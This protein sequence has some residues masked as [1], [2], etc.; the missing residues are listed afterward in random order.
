MTAIASHSGSSAS[1][2]GAFSDMDIESSSG[3]QTAFEPPT[4]AHKMIGTLNLVFAG[5]LLMCGACTGISF[6]LQVAM[7]PMTEG[8]QNA[9]QEAMSAQAEQ[10]REQK[11]DSLKEQVEAATSDDD[12]ARIEAEIDE[13]QQQEPVEIPKFDMMAA[14]RDPQIIGFMWTDLITALVLNILLFVSGL[15]LLAAKAWARKLAIW[16]AALKIVRLVTLYGYSIAVVVPIYAQ[17]MSQMMEQM[18]ASM[19][20]RPGAPAMPPMG[21]TLGTF[22]GVAMSAGAVLMILVGVIYPIVVLWVL[23]RPKVKAACGETSALR[24]AESP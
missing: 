5:L 23:T 8:Y 11:I 20:K 10:E 13:L 9:M 21:Q 17:K 22:Y 15:G 1:T 4:S 3:G 18:T 12:R 24:P 7:A 16:T 6:L 2:P 19:P 14:Y